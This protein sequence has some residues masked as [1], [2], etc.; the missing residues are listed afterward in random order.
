MYFENYSI[1]VYYQCV[2]YLILSVWSHKR[3]LCLKYMSYSTLLALTAEM[4]IYTSLLLSNKH[5][6]YLYMYNKENCCWASAMSVPRR[7]VHSISLH[8][9]CYYCGTSQLFIPNNQL[10]KFVREKGQCQKISCFHWEVKCGFHK[11]RIDSIP[12]RILNT[13]S[14]KT[15]FDTK[16][17]QSTGLVLKAVLTFGIFKTFWQSDRTKYCI[18]NCDAFHNKL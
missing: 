5:F 11:E 10:I 1:K 6:L 8:Y 14:N 18:V 9:Y 2:R 15:N 13:S 16:H 3:V 4:C 7:C 12:D 17:H